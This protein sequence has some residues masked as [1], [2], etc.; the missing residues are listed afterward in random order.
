MSDGYVYERS[1]SMMQHTQLQSIILIIVLMFVAIGLI[2]VYSTSAV[3]AEIDPHMKSPYFFV[4]KQLVWVLLAGA[5]ML[6][7]LE[8]SYRTIIRYGYHIFGFALLLLI[9]V[10]IPGIGIEYNGARR[11][12]RFGGMGFQPSDAMKLAAIILCAKYIEEN[13]VWLKHFYS[14]FLPIFGVLGFACFL[15]LLEPDFGTACFVMLICT[16]LL[17]VGGIDWRHMLPVTIAALPI[18]T[19]MVIYKF[20]HIS[21][22]INTYLNPDMD[23]LGK[24]YQIRQSLMALGSGG[25]FGVGLGWSKQKLFF[26][27][28][29]STDFIFA[30]LGEELGFL[31]TAAVILLYTLFVYYGFQVVRRAP[32]IAGMILS[33]GIVISIAI[34]SIFNIAV[35]THT[36]PAK[37]I[38]LPLI[39]FGGSG[40]VFSMMGVGI[41]LNIAGHS[42]KT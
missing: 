40:L 24:G 2:M 14:G 34:Q 22:R 4:K 7:C 21:S 11:W 15:I 36:I 27:S 25:L 41:L 29:E 16:I 13:A 5:A 26:L 19:I 23:P 12:I 1:I 20:H 31:G 3:V 8:I 18:I 37:G 38:S 6:L 17:R 30:I 28:E 32:D 10:L 42:A 35:V 39:S 33:L 9:L